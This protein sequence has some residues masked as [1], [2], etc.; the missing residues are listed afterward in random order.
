MHNCK[1]TRSSLTDLAMDEVQPL[2]KE[3]LLTELQDC[4]ACQEEYAAIRNVLRLSSQGL[5][6]TLPA[7][8]FWPGYHARLVDRIENHSASEQQPRF[9]WGS[10]LWL[11]V[12]KLATTSV[13][14]PVPVAAAALV[15][16]LAVST[17]V[18]WPARRLVV[19]A[20]VPSVSVITNTVEVPVIQEKVVTRVVYVEKYRNRTRNGPGRLDQLA[21]AAPGLA[22]ANPDA[23]ATTAISLVGFKPTDQVKL[24][25]MKGSY[26]D[27]K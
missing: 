26:R 15:L 3:Q 23:S 16:L 1:A 14:V 12:R 7:E 24:K 8:E 27:E 2:L 19:P 22:P 25:V 4:P 9:V 20:P 13:R 17:F 18:A 11:G 21:N 5:R 6:S 10:R